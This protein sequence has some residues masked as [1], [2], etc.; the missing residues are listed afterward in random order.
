[1]VAGDDLAWAD[2]GVERGMGNS[3]TAM[4]KTLAGYAGSVYWLVY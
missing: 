4:A 1:V 3:Q 2:F